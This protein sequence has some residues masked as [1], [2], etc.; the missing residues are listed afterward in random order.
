MRD[1]ANRADYTGLHHITYS[2]QVKCSR[3]Y[4]L[5]SCSPVVGQMLSHLRFPAER[6]TA[7]D[8]MGKCVSDKQNVQ[9][10]LV[11]YLALESND[12]RVYVIKTVASA[13]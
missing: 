10:H 3:L 5:L 6:K 2:S 7:A 9:D 11:P 1:R 4:P 13:D 12:I 8:I